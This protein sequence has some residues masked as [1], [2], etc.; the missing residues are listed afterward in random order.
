MPF[1]VQLAADTSSAREAR[2]FVDSV[3]HEWKCDAQIDRLQLVVSELVTNALLHAGS[4]TEVHLVRTQSRLRLEVC[5]YGR[6][7]PAIRSVH[8]GEVQGGRGLAIVEQL[9]TAWGVSEWRE[10]KCIWVEV[11]V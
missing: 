9:A 1:S 6:G 4:A 3:L 2:Q 8:D 11:D 5:D 7:L 10:G